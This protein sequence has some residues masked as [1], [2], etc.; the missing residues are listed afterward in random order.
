[1]F[2]ANFLVGGL[3]SEV[4]FNKIVKTSKTKFAYRLEDYGFQYELFASELLDKFCIMFFMLFPFALLRIVL[5]DFKCY[6]K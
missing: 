6:K 4:T 3:I 5:M 2:S 1:M